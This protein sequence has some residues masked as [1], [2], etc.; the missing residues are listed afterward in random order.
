MGTEERQKD[1]DNTGGVGVC[2]DE[3]QVLDR[4]LTEILLTDR[5]SGRRIIW[6][7]E[8][9]AE[10]GEGYGFHDEIPPEKGFLIQPRVKKNVKERTRRSRDKGEVFTPAWVC[11][12]QA[13][14][15]DEVWFGG[16]DIFNRETKKGWETSER[17]IPF[18]NVPG[19]T[20][21][22]YVKETRL[23]ITCG[24]APY[25]V[26]RYDAVTGTA[27]PVENR[28]GL[29]DRK[30]RVV[31]ENTDN[32]E[33]WFTWAQHAYCNTYGYE[34]QG[35][36]LFLARKNLIFS[37]IEYFRKRWGED[38]APSHEMLQ[39]IAEI[40]SWNIWQMD[41]LKFVIPDT[42]H[43]EEVR[44]RDLFGKEEVKK[45]PCPGCAKN[46]YF[47]HNGITCVIRDWK[48]GEKVIPFVSLLHRKDR[49]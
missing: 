40:I 20:W 27:I 9:Y 48:D 38:A 41:G 33:D 39:R 31:G 25:L 28:I 1:A 10:R 23:E 15:V 11:N 42:C 5:S 26:S 34:W 7:T 29:L 16:K 19:K 45:I 36:N 24:E 4:Q 47:D 8:H 22:D 13:N 44:T 6:A 46:S 30:L 14:L 35:D 49:T 21:Q 2:D 18:P 12:V 37:F 3:S 17:R 43:E 32:P